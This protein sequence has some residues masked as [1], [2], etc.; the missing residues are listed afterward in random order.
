V[1]IN[2]RN[3][4]RRRIAAELAERAGRE[5]VKLHDEDVAAMPEGRHYVR[6]CDRAYESAARDTYHHLTNSRVYRGR[7]GIGLPALQRMLSEEI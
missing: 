3:R 5:A 1:T 2:K 7:L 6:C 4:L